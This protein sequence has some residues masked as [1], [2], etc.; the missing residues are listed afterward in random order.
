MICDARVQPA[1]I[2]VM[3][4]QVVPFDSYGQAVDWVGQR[5]ALRQKTFCVAINPEKLHHCSKDA[6]LAEALRDADAGICDGIGTALAAMVLHWRR[7]RRCTGC[8]LFL[9]LS[10]AAAERQWKVF[11]LG[12]SEESNERAARGLRQ[13]HPGLRI[14]GRRDGYFDSEEAVVRQVNESG[15]DL[16][17]VAMGS[18]RQEIFIHRNRR[19]IDAPFVMGVGGSFDVLSGKAKRAPAL[20][21]RTG[22]EF[23]FRLIT[24][25]GRWRRQLALPAFL[26]ELAAWKLGRR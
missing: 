8:D 7:V 25:P 20:F 24:S 26:A 5:L 9:H 2:A 1:P 12:A 3:G 11:L 18:P 4:A 16:L 19:Q 22:T 13:R 17:F 14:V 10:A 21:R 23:L 15:A 6:L